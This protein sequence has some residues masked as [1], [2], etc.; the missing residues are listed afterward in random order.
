[1]KQ[2]SVKEVLRSFVDSLLFR[3]YHKDTFGE[4]A[5]YSM[6]AWFMIFYLIAV[7]IQLA[8]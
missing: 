8:R 1:M 6:T 5:I 7:I 2:P 4:T 3:K